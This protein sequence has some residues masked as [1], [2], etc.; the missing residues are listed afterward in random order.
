[1]TVYYLDD[2]NSISF[3]ILGDVADLAQCERELDVMYE[4]WSW[5]VEDILDEL[6]YLERETPQ[7]HNNALSLV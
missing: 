4:F 3:N 7:P 2:N 1:M 6:I 5:Y